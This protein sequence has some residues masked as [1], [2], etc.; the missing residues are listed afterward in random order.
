LD[1]DSI[2]EMFRHVVAADTLPVMTWTLDG[3]LTAVNDPLLELLGYTRGEFD[4]G[5]ID[6]DGF[7]PPEYWLLDE[8]SIDQIL[9]LRRCAPYVKEF[10]RKD[11][12]RV[13]VY[14]FSAWEPLYPGTGSTIVVELTEAHTDKPRAPFYSYF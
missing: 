9:R 13:P 3:V 1:A 12:S 6:G 11:G 10:F 14:V 8:R 7:T 2:V 4:A 5:Q